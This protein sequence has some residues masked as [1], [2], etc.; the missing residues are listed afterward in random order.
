MHMY[1]LIGISLKI[2]PKHSAILLEVIYGHYLPN[3]CETHVFHANF[4]A[5]YRL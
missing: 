2:A 4:D 3:S 1:R 5:M